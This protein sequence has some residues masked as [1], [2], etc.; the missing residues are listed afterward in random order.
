VCGWVMVLTG[1]ARIAHPRRSEDDPEGF[2]WPE[3]GGLDGG[4]ATAFVGRTLHGEQG[5]LLGTFLHAPDERPWDELMM[6]M[7]K[8][9]WIFPRD[10]VKSPCG[11]RRASAPS[12]ASSLSGLLQRGLQHRGPLSQK[13]ALSPLS[14]LKVLRRGDRTGSN[15]L[16]LDAEDHRRSRI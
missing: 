11:C 14:G 12:F 4:S 1:T 10:S 2:R 3:R 8:S 13:D 9:C 7:P 6:S 5:S 16:D 15:R